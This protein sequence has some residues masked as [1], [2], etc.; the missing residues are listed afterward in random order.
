M[1]EILKLTIES[2]VHGGDG[3]AHHGGKVVFVPFVVPGEEVLATVVQD[4]GG[5][6]KAELTE[7]VTSSPDR[8]EAPCQYFQRCGGCQWQHIAYPAQL[9][10]KRQVVIEQLRRIG[11][12]ESPQ[13]RP[14]IGMPNPWN[15]RNQSRFTARRSGH[16]GFTDTTGKEFLRIDECL[17]SQPAINTVLERMQGRKTAVKL[18]QL[19]VRTGARSDE[20]VVMP[21]IE[22]IPVESGQPGYHE[23]ILGQSFWVSSPSFFQVNTVPQMRSGPLA[24]GSPPDPSQAEILALLVREILDL[25]GGETVVDAYCGVGIE[26]S[27]SSLKDAYMNAEGVLNV[28]FIAGRVEH[29]LPSLE[30]PAQAVVIDPPRA[31]CK[32]EVLDAMIRTQPDTIA[33]VSCEPATL[34]RDLHILTDGGFEIE[35]VQP[36]DM[37]PQTYHIETVVSIRRKGQSR[38]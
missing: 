24:P 21:R 13:V 37:F 22:G 38:A 29:V 19:A 10:A 15:Y 34:A 4:H 18:H 12:F 8:V 17:I 28:R 3:M 36:V 31:G 9:E 5:Y 7:I 33:Y 26:E 6:L 27:A 2:L 14:T 20:L 23:D 30:I 32:P 25:S 1:T 11:K 35:S 16:L